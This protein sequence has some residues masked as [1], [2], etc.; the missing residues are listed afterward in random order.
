MHS[1][2]NYLTNNN[3]QMGASYNV[4]KKAQAAVEAGYKAAAE[5]VNA[6]PDEIVIGVST[7]QLLRNLSYSLNF[8]SGSEIII[9]IMD[10]ESNISP[11]VALAARQ[12][13]VVKWWK[14]KDKKNPKLEVGDLDG[15]L[16]EKTKLVAL[17]H[18][19][20]IIGSVH[21]VRGIGEK[22]HGNGSGAVVVVD[23]V[24][25]APHRRVDVKELGVDFYVFSWYK[26][27]RLLLFLSL[28]PNLRFLTSDP[29]TLSFVLF[30][31]PTPHFSNVKGF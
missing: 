23:G 17:T 14:P 5:Y 24:A 15:L 22:V 13:L 20:N 28:R 29:S 31:F 18:C 4:G 21:D 16:S 2:A 30:R 7:T 9:S 12:Q 10:H 25:F 19:S 26:V 6:S 11:W 27:G 3:V 8:P 1:I